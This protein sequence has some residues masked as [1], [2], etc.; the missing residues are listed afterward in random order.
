MLE[1]F[2]ESDAQ[3]VFLKLVS[4]ED[5]AG[6]PVLEKLPAN[7]TDAASEKHVPAVSADK[8][9]VT[10]KIGEIAHPMLDEHF[11]TM[12]CIE[13]KKGGQF[14]ILSPGDAPEAVFMLAEGDEFIAAY[15]YCNLHGLWTG[16]D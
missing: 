16:R 9:Q 14:R 1:F 11:I 10:V 4:L 3:N 12:I 15:E 6:M 13:T 7:D 8:N 5:Q 2:K